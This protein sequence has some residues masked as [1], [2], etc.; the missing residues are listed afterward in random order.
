LKLEKAIK[1]IEKAL[2][3]KVDRPTDGRGRYWFQYGNQVGSFLSQAEYG[4][5]ED[6]TY[7]PIKGQ[8]EAMNWHVRRDNDHSDPHTDY[9]AGYHLDNCTQLIENLKPPV[10]KFPIGC[11]VRGK[12][13]KRATRQGYAGKTGIVIESGLYLKIKW[14]DLKVR[15][16]YL[17]YPERDMELVSA[18]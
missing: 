11:L 6:G 13:N 9:F 14:M 1:K 2:G 7:G 12:E 15:Y 16:D 3:V 8:W 5:R 17:T 10:A 4:T 18:A